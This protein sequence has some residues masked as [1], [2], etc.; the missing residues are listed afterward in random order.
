MNDME[1]R[2]CVMYGVSFSLCEKLDSLGVYDY[3]TG[4]VHSEEVKTMTI[5]GWDARKGRWYWTLSGFPP[6]EQGYDFY[7]VDEDL[8]LEA[9][10][11]MMSEYGG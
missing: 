1:K 5:V 6:R 10:K 8:F 7:Y 2:G 9:V 11:S 3:Y 4:Y